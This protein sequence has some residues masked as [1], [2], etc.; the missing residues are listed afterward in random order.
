MDYSVIQ[1]F[2]AEVYSAFCL[3]WAEIGAD[4]V[5]RGSD[6]YEYTTVNILELDRRVSALAAP[7][8]QPPVQHLLT[9]PQVKRFFELHP[10]YLPMQSLFLS[11]LHVQLSTLPQTILL[12]LAARQNLELTKQHVHGPAVPNEDFR[13][14]SVRVLVI[15]DWS[16]GTQS[17]QFQLRTLD[18]D[19]VPL[20]ERFPELKNSPPSMFCEALTAAT[21][22]AVPLVVQELSHKFP[23][24]KERDKPVSIAAWRELCRLLPEAIAS[25]DSKDKDKLTELASRMLTAFNA[26]AIMPAAAIRRRVQEKS[27]KGVSS[28]SNGG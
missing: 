13:P 20:F 27:S 2:S 16:D 28:D 12:Q 6:Q 8:G 15:T 24:L 21:E 11:T 10:C 23:C 5:P 25:F 14:V 1:P 19:M 9:H 26:Q 7:N 17:Q 22:V 18:M 4:V 3:F